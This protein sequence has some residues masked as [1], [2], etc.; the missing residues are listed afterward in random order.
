MTD[1]LDPKA[2]A[3][4]HI[5]I[6]R[7]LGNLASGNDFR[8]HPDFEPGGYDVGFGMMDL[9]VHKPFATFEAAKDFALCFSHMLAR[10]IKEDRGETTSN[11]KP[12]DLESLREVDVFGGRTAYALAERYLKLMGGGPYRIIGGLR[13]CRYGWL[14]RWDTVAIWKR[15]GGK[16]G[17]YAWEGESP[18][19]GR[20]KMLLVLPPTG[21]I[22]VLDPAPTIEER[23]QEFERTHPE[24]KPVYEISPEYNT[25]VNAGVE[26]WRADSV[27]GL[28][29]IH[30]EIVWRS[31]KAGDFDTRYAE[32]AREIIERCAAN[33]GVNLDAV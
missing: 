17:W 16:R 25:L 24:F 10:V 7:C 8:C 6:H 3:A 12:Y 30:I 4:R 13:Q 1:Q 20:K 9:N 21:Q 14:V 19:E 15:W 2:S 28:S 26:D 31:F 11:S 22:A 27:L 29:T 5:H 33:A 32:D 23:L 18:P